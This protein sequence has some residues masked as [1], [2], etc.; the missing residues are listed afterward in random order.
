MKKS[1]CAWPRFALAL[2]YAFVPTRPRHSAAAC[3]YNMRTPLF[4][5]LLRRIGFIA[6]FFCYDLT[7]RWESQSGGRH[8][9][10]TGWKISRLGI[11]ARTFQRQPAY[12]VL[13][14]LGG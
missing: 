12:L 14:A 7:S 8:A 3:F 13:E 10:A 5:R 1:R 4:N 11:H 6:T 2:S 9:T